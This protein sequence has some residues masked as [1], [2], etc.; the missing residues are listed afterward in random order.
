MIRVLLHSFDVVIVDG[1]AV[2]VSKTS[3]FVI[4]AQK[5]MGYIR[6]DWRFAKARH[7]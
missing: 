6:F 3:G 4:L 7:I 1:A 5:C 2:F